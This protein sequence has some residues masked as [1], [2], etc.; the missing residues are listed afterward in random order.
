MTRQVACVESS[1]NLYV[2]EERVS[3]D[4][5][6]GVQKEDV[7]QRGEE[8]SFHL[9]RVQDARDGYKVGRIRSRGSFCEWVAVSSV[10]LLSLATPIHTTFDGAL[11]TPRSPDRSSGAGCHHR[12][13]RWCLL[14]PASIVLGPTPCTNLPTLA[15]GWSLLNT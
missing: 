12:S 14:R 10:T 9:A 3:P 15:L 13:Q 2:I 1:P 4:D 8:G 6:H 7:E 5:A 11:E